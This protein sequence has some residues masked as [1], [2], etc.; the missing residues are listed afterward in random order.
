MKKRSQ[1][2][3]SIYGDLALI[4]FVAIPLPMTGVFTGAVASRLFDIPKKRS[5]FLLSIG[6][7]IAGII[8]SVLTVLGKLVI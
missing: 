7:F 1:K 2:K 4:L 3:F 6:V 5:I 8:V